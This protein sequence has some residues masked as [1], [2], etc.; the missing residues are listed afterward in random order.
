MHS[1]EYQ[2]WC[3][4]PKLWLML[5]IKSWD[6]V[7]YY[8]NI[9]CYFD[10]ILYNYYDVNKILHLLDWYFHLKPKYLNLNMYCGIKLRMMRWKIVSEHGKWV[11]SNTLNSQSEMKEVFSR[12][13]WYE[14]KVIPWGQRP[15]KKFLSLEFKPEEA[16]YFQSLVGIMRWIVE[17]RHIDILMEFLFFSSHL[18]LPREGHRE[19]AVHTEVYLEV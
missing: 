19:V 12:E 7:K 11:L 10:D 3:S 5:I 13:P 15:R 16:C 4:Y 1:I 17:L 14:L 2:S 18:A 9:L 8:P 6:W